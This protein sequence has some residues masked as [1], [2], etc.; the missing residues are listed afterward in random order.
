LARPAWW[1]RARQ[2]FS[3]DAPRMAVR[4]RL[5]WPW[6]AVVGVGLVAV[7]VGMWW[8]GF[9]FGQI[10]GG[11]NRKEIE[12]RIAALE[13]E[14]AQLRIETAQQRANGTR[15]ESELA[16]AT[17]AQASLSRQALELQNENSQI[18][19][20]LV[21]LQKL[22]ADSN[23][24]VGLAI[25]RVVVERE[26]EDAWHYSLLV[27]RGGNPKDEFDGRVTLQVTL[28][29]AAGGAAP[30][31]TIVTLPDDQP[32]A[33]GA[34]ALKFKYYQRLE[35]T[36]TTPSDSVVRAVTVRAF[37]TGQQSPR[38]TRNLVIP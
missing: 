28:Q 2:H 17:G 18:K 32:A 25:Q 12:S 4:S 10:F 19:E 37:E 23:K 9:D 20:E 14:N 6:R 24:Q 34:L 5:P 7:V 35:G 38:A 8:W 27:V 22:V 30:K 36:I 26:R 3:I 13:T 31:Q 29:A 1:R 21:F 33:A 16:M 15:L 11:F